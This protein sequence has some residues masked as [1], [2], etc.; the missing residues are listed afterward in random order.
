MNSRPKHDGG[1]TGRLLALPLLGR[2]A[3]PADS[4]AVQYAWFSV[5]L[6]LL[7]WTA[8]ALRVAMMLPVEPSSN[9]VFKLTE[10]VDKRRVLSATGAGP[11]ES[12]S[13]H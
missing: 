5:P 4:A 12:L 2:L 11:G 8:A 10:P 6:G 9:W 1:S 3:G 7:C 13:L